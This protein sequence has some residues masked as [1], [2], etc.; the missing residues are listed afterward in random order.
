MILPAHSPALLV[1]WTSPT[2]GVQGLALLLTPLE[3]TRP[4]DEWQKRLRDNVKTTG[5]ELSYNPASG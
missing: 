5:D 3:V 2:V 4:V 1:G